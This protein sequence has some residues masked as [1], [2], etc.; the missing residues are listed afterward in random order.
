MV[1]VCLRSPLVSRSCCLWIRCALSQELDFWAPVSPSQEKMVTKPQLLF[2]LVLLPFPILPQHSSLESFRICLECGHS[3]CQ[4]SDQAKSPNTCSCD[5]AY[6]VHH[7][8]RPGAG[9]GVS[10]WGCTS[11]ERS[12]HWTR[13][14]RIWTPVLVPVLCG[15]RQIT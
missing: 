15:A 5:K 13:S 12:E 8:S 7:K 11:G 1:R 10:G 4:G 6:P 14:L 9:Q 2:F 3:R